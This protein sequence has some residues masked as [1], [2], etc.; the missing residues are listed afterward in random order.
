MIT[1]CRFHAVR[2]FCQ[3]FAAIWET[4]QLVNVNEQEKK[5]MFSHIRS[6]LITHV[7]I[8]LQ[9]MQQITDLKRLVLIILGHLMGHDVEQLTQ[10]FHALK[11]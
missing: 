4:G 8:N 2:R 10:V 1:I 11:T 7:Y 5:P 6:G 3:T 9:Q